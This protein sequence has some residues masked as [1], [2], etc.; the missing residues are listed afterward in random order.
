MR[1]TGA[2]VI[3]GLEFPSISA[4]ER[5]LKNLKVDRKNYYIICEGCENQVYFVKIVESWRDAPLMKNVT[6]DLNSIK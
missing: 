6:I 3:K 4:K 1:I 2:G 5:Y